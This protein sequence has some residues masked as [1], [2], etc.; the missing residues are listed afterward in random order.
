MSTSEALAMNQASIK[1]LVADNVIAALEVQAAIMASTS[2][3]NRNTGLTET[4]VAKIGNY[5]EFISCQ[6]FYFN[7]T[8]GAVGLIRWFERTESVFSRS[9]CAEENK[10]TFAIGTLTDDALSWWNAYAQPMG[11]DQAN[12]I[13]WTEFKRHLTNNQPYIGRGPVKQSAGIGG[14]STV[15]RCHHQRRLSRD[16]GFLFR[17]L[18]DSRRMLSDYNDT[19]TDNPCRWRQKSSRSHVTL[20]GSSCSVL[21]FDSARK[22]EAMEE[23]IPLREATVRARRLV[24]ERKEK[25][26]RTLFLDR[27]AKFCV[28][29]TK[30]TWREEIIITAHQKHRG[31]ESD[32]SAEILKGQV[33]LVIYYRPG[34]CRMARVIDSSA[35]IHVYAVPQLNWV[36]G[37]YSLVGLVGN[38]TYY[39]PTGCVHVSDGLLGRGLR[40]PVVQLPNKGFM[41]FLFYGVNEMHIGGF[42]HVRKSS[43]DLFGVPA[44]C[45]DHPGISVAR[46]VK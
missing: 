21:R 29:E 22:E 11:I 31:Y 1:K 46:L 34:I 27:S 2:N 30:K 32:I 3:P 35:C 10:V 5:K 14:C 41:R 8:E 42:T 24:K 19:I 23:N 18:K 26:G 20:G 16:A 9:K 44:H 37:S 39:G 33:S 45:C 25:G 6:P 36:T 15:G 28:K 12:Q 7:G 13:T 4:P 38:S 17:V 43:W 40:W